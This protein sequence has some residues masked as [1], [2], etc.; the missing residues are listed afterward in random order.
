MATAKATAASK[1]AI[2]KDEP[3]PVEND[4]DGTNNGDGGGEGGT[5]NRNA[6]AENDKAKKEHEEALETLEP[7]TE[8]REWIIGK[9]P[10]EGGED[11]EY[12]RYVQRPLGYMQRMRYFAL[13]SSTITEAIKA[14]GTINMGATDL[15]GG[16]GSLRQRAAALTDA[17]FAD[18]GSFMALAFQLL[19]YSPDFLLES[20]C[21]WLDVPGKEKGWAKRVMSQPRDPSRN[22]WGLT[23]EMGLG[24]VE[25]FI[26]QN[27]E[28][29][30]RFF[31]EKVPKLL[32]RLRQREDEQ[33]GHESESDLS[34]Q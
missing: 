3:E 30:R 32:T 4:N 14:G 5:S 7:M 18:A 29:T 9:P 31:V 34:K 33:K 8:P 11:D 23:D 16:E 21:M 6:E 13:V 12:S 26:D 19:A 24:M 2:S 20:Y 17:D 22:K 15:F 1:K 28:D 27:Y 10:T 25:T